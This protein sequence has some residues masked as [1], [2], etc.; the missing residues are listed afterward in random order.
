MQVFYEYF[1]IKC[2]GQTTEALHDMQMISIRK[3]TWSEFSRK[4][5]HLATLD[6]CI[7]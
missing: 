4:S 5:F 6:L 3:G 1:A 7:S 2:V